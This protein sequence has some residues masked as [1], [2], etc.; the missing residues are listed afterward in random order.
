MTLGRTRGSLVK[1]E[2]EKTV[3]E[4]VD[5][6]KAFSQKMIDSGYTRDVRKEIL[7][8]GIKRYYRLRLN[9]EAGVRN[10]YRTPGEMKASRE[11]KNTSARAWFKPRRG[12]A[13]NKIQKDYPVRWPEGRTKERRSGEGKV[14]QRKETDKEGR[15]NEETGKVMNVETPIFIPFTKES[16]LKR[17]LQDIDMMIPNELKSK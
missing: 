14:N 6:L 16:A 10:L 13:R 11:K 5:I 17:R 7:E 8:S 12:G 15:G 2:P 3:E 9:Q 4:R 1:F